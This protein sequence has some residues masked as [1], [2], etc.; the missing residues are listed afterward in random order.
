[1]PF[2]QKLP[3]APRLVHTRLPISMCALSGPQVR[4][5]SDVLAPAAMPSPMRQPVGTKAESSACASAESRSGL[6]PFQRPRPWL[7]YANDG[8]NL[9]QKLP[10]LIML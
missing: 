6:P 9:F 1:M 4:S 8:V 5:L 10:Q 3:P 2:C 7:F